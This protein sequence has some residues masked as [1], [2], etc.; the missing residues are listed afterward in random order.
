MSKIAVLFLLSIAAGYGQLLPGREL[1][2]GLFPPQLKTYLELTDAQVTA[3]TKA[4]SDLNAFRAGKVQRQFQ[5]QME[6]AQETAKQ[7]VDP[8]ALGLRHAELEVIQRE[9]AA[10][11][12]KTATAVQSLLTAPQKAKLATLQQALQLYSLACTA[13]DQN[14]LDAPMAFAGNII[15]A[16]RI[17]PTFAS[18]LLGRVALPTCGGT[19]SGAFR[20]GDFTST[21]TP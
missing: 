14:V 19:G 11:Q 2:E 13:V 7:T 15:P 16:N 9:I 12:K 1:I 18:F 3:M 17:D 4:N 5:V 21:V 8:M 6:L 20:F 10:E